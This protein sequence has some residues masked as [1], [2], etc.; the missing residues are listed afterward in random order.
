M[1][2]VPVRLTGSLYVPERADARQGVTGQ[3]ELIPMK[4][5]IAE[6]K[7][8]GDAEAVFALHGDLDIA[9]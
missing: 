4:A 5:G 6:S 2:E 8:H 9:G 1:G 7:L 3:G